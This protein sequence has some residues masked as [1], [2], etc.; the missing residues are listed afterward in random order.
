LCRRSGCFRRRRRLR[1]RDCGRCLPA[2]TGGKGEGCHG[3]EAHAKGKRNHCC[4]HGPLPP[5]CRAAGALRARPVVAV[6]GLAAC[7]VSPEAAT[8]ARSNT[9]RT[10]TT[11]KAVEG[12]HVWPAF[13]AFRTWPPLVS[14]PFPS[15]GH[16]PPRWLSDPRVAP[17]STEVYRAAVP[18]T[19]FPAGFTVGVLHIERD[20]GAEHSLFAMEKRSDGRWDY[21]VAD[22][23]GVI[24]ERGR[25]AL[26]ERCHAEAPSDGL[27]GLPRLARGEN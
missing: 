13:A 18:G 20:S 19:R 10:P 27:F 21:V 15:R 6:L 3:A 2:G 9:P 11:E 17:G 22:R 4:Y 12:A 23:S 7:A 26:C 16:D 1:N 25:L 8:R 5:R 14:E 24:R